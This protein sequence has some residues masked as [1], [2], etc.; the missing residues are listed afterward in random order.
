MLILFL[1]FKDRTEA[2]NVD[3]CVLVSEN[4]VLLEPRCIKF[5]SHKA[6]QVFK[7]EMLCLC[8]YSVQL[9]LCLI[10]YLCV[11]YVYV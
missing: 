7:S 6:I 11:G 1:V 8:W 5:R 9:C 4:I 3:N 2:A 10:S